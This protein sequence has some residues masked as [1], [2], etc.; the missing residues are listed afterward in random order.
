LRVDL[1]DA[2]ER[3]RPSVVQVRLGDPMDRAGRV[4]GT[5]FLVHRDG[6][7]LT[8]RHVTEHALSLQ[9]KS[10]K[11]RLLAGLAIPNFESP[12]LSIR[13][14]FELLEIT[15]VEQDERHDLALLR[16]SPNPFATGKPS[17]VSLT[18]TG[19]AVNAL[20][21]VAQTEAARPRDGDAIAVSGYPLSEPTLVTTSGCVASA[22]GTDIREVQPPAAPQGFT[23]PDVKDSYLADVAVNP[24][25][26]G[27]PVYVIY[28]ARVIGVCVAF[29]VASAEDAAANAFSY[30][31]GLSVVVPIGYGLALL[32]KHLEGATGSSDV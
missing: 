21:G 9:K 1:P 26:S 6:Y 2:I 17:G 30:N 14:S 24:G 23:I 27:G 4:I 16:L 12:Q 28:T 10:P 7:A 5:G 15:V 25:N 31:S 8:A 32:R 11:T 29:R 20:F 3:V 19:V 22:W 13:A 18:E